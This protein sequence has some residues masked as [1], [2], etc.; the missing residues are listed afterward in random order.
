[1][2][3][4]KTLSRFLLILLSCA[5]LAACNSSSDEDTNEPPADPAAGNAPPTIWGEPATSVTAGTQYVFT[6]EAEDEEGDVLTFSVVNMPEWATFEETSGELR[7]V[8]A[9]GDAGSYDEIVISVTD[10]NS[11][12]SLPAFS[13]EV[14]EQPSQGGDDPGDDP[15]SQ[16]PT[17]TGDPNEFVV[18]GATYAFQPE[19]SDPEDDTLS[20]SITNKP[21][22]ATFDTATGRLE[23][24]P[25]AADA[26][27]GA[28]IEVSVTDGTSIAALASFSITVQE[29][30][31]ASYTLSW[32]PPTQ[33]EDGTALTDLAGY[34]IYYGMIS[35]EYT[36]QL[37]LNQ[38]GVTSYQ[39][40][41]IAPGKYFLV[42]TALN[43]QDMESRHSAELAL[44]PTT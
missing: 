5:A 38:P 33:N 23:G 37:V 22:W 16:A 9:A 43:S 20:F 18:A 2:K 42:M 28:P 34:K 21:A 12:A 32:D 1:M 7:G 15:V 14:T 36:E 30:G 19:A 44:E 26:G 17:I 25:T 40:N 13:I 3:N 29:T 27:T 35:G 10:D 11:V 39:L 4:E 31:T 6:P 24:T 41:G 8:P